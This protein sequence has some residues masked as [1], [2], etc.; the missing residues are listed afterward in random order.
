[1]R[2]I[3]ESLLDDEDAVERIE[4][5]IEE[6]G[7]PTVRDDLMAILEDPTRAASEWETVAAVFWGAVLDGREV[8]ADR[9]I[10]LLYARLPNDGGSAENN[11]AWSITSKLRGV[12][13]LSAYNPLADGKVQAELASIRRAC[14]RRT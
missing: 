11:L 13:Y 14:R 4:Q 9:L 3:D 10:A 8:N 2:A 5:L 6:S 7:W 12:D 1:M